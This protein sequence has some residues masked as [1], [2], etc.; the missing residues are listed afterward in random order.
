MGTSR[1]GGSRL[2]GQLDNPP[3]AP[4]HLKLHGHL[5]VGMPDDVPQLQRAHLAGTQAD[6]TQQPQ[7]SPVADADPSRQVGL[8]QQPLV[9]GG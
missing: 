4:G 2:G 3:L 8:K 9:L 5:A 6:V 1:P 7:D